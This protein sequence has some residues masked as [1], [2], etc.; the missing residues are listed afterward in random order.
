MDN[1]LKIYSAKGVLLLETPINEGCKW[2]YELMKDDYITVKFSLDEAELIHF[3]IGSYTE[4]NGE[5]W[6]IT[7]TQDPTLDTST[8]GYNYELTFKH[9]YWLWNNK[10]FKFCPEYGGR[11]A[12]WLWCNDLESLMAV[13]LKNLKQHGYNYKGKDYSVVIAADVEKAPHTITFSNAGLVDALF[14]SNM[15][16]ETWNTECYIENGI[17]HFGKCQTTK[18]P[19][20]FK[21]GVNVEK[22][23]RSNSKS[24]YANRLYVFGGTNN[25]PARYR[26]KLIFNVT[27]VSGDRIYDSFRVLK[28]DFF[29]DD[30]KTY[31]AA[32]TST[33]HIS[34]A[35]TNVTKSP[36]NIEASFLDNKEG[37]VPC[38]ATNVTITP[39]IDTTKSYNAG[40][41]SNKYNAQDKYG[42]DYVIKAELKL[43]YKYKD[44][45]TENTIDIASDE[46]TMTLN[47][48]QFDHNGKNGRN[49]FKFSATFS[50][51]SL[52]LNGEIEPSFLD[53]IETGS[54]QFVL[55]AS[56]SREGTSIPYED[57]HLKTS[58]D[59]SMTSADTS[60]ECKATITFISGKQ[61]GNTYT[62]TVN[63]YHDP[64]LFNTIDVPY[65]VEQAPSVGDKFTIDNIIANEVPT[66]Y[67]V[68]DSA[69]DLV[70]NGVVQNRLMLPLDWN[71]GENYIDAEDGLVDAEI[72]EAIVTNDDIYPRF[73][74]VDED[75][76]VMNGRPCTAVKT[77]QGQVTNDTTN[78]KED[79]T[80]WAFQDSN[81][82]FKDEYKLSNASDGLQVQFVS[83]K[84]NGLIF[85][86]DFKDNGTSTSGYGSGQWFE[87]VRNE[88][89][90]RP[91][92]DD[93]LYPTVG[94]RYVL[95]GWD[96]SYISSLG[97]V[98]AAE[99]E[100]L[101]WGKKHIKETMIDPSTYT[102][103]MMSD[104]AYGYNP[105]TDKLDPD[106]SYD[107][108]L[109]LGDPVML[110]S[111]AYFASGTRE[112]RVIG[113][114]KYL[115]FIWDTPQYIIGE[116]ATYSTLS[117]LSDKVDE[118]TLMGQT[119]M[120]TS[121][122]GTSIYLITTNDNTTPTDRNA[123]SALRA[124]QMFLRKDT[125]DT[126]EGTITFNKQSV[127]NK[128]AQ[129]GSSFAAGMTGYG[130]RIDGDGNA[131]LDSLSVRH[132]LEVPEIRYNKATVILGDQWHSPGG[133]I[134]ESCVP[135]TETVTNDDGTTTVNTLST[136]TITLKLED[137]EI[138]AIAVDDIC[139][140]YFHFLTGGNAPDTSD[141]SKG[142]RTMAGFTTIY[143]RV[144]E[145]VDD[146]GTNKTFKYALRPV[147]DNWTTQAHPQE[148]LEFTVYGN[149]TDKERQTSAYSTRT[150]TRYLAGV[151]D[152]EFTKSNIMMQ[153]GD[154]TNLSAFEYGVDMTGYSAYLNNIYMSGTI[155]QFEDIGY[156]M[157]VDTSGY[158][159]IAY[160]ETMDVKCTIYDGYMQ[161]KTSLATS[162]SVTRDSGDTDADKIWNAAHTDFSGEITLSYTQ[163]V[164]DLRRTDGV[165]T[166]FT[167]KAEV[168]GKTTKATLAS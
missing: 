108:S 13:F 160:G 159:R 84:L 154:L 125:D 104:N 52:S 152:W 64:D 21:L 27:N 3:G 68:T 103:D 72:V 124:K 100:L 139:M 106:Y 164:N 39:T 156:R 116:K 24:T 33:L 112:S 14:G 96:S 73:T 28:P 8:G 113:F 142:N 168:D 134:V 20:D 163:E 105:N 147:S 4:W 32:Q 74:T 75:G 26:K 42:G 158:D 11:E 92:P 123:Y 90:G 165:S 83:G 57:I 153:L 17:I 29:P 78:E 9:D 53:Y 110:Y 145:I 155:Q 67:F 126:A 45:D 34:E 111:N 141:D 137:G 138:G 23:S 91:L 71:N 121:T 98:D 130:G 61:K 59:I 89:Y 31:N 22:F 49:Y 46:L 5:T 166:V 140:G 18:T 128:G 88:D 143:F 87:L 25:I 132:F 40:Q 51:T 10:I 93:T 76:N 36:W 144:T 19:V 161:D 79:V 114:E 102:C 118:L 63:P 119:Y 38:K 47:N 50:K 167:F 48:P 150:Y 55:S 101:A 60:P 54:A 1:T 109:L 146:S 135:D 117:N 81:L 107:K 69:D 86:L 82:T 65:D 70:L 80:F 66:A 120:G 56:V 133:G 37:A 85:Q 99:K 162:W 35:S 97:L 129:F 94:D 115:D 58:G 151:N 62:A 148:A 30:A 7:E 127:H 16:A 149:F 41:W 157:D 43:T 15:I 44:S 122:G 12:S 2:K 6:I 136:G 77:R 131:W 95:I